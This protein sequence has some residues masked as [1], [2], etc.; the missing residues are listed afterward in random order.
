MVGLNITTAPDARYSLNLTGEDALLT[1]E[2]AL[3][4]IAASAE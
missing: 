2:S 4:I 1:I 3:V